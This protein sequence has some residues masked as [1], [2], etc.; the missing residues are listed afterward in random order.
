MGHT[1]VVFQALSFDKL[2]VQKITERV[3]EKR[4]GQTEWEATKLRTRTR[5]PGIQQRQHFKR[6]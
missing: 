2:C 4:R 6:E 3:R 1:E 5:L